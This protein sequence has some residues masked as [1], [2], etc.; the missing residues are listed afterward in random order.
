MRDGYLRKIDYLRVSITDRCNLRCFYCLPAGGIPTSPQG[1]IL[2]FEELLELLGVATGNGI[3]RVRITGGEPLVRKG[4]IAFLSRVKA[5]PGV[6][7]LSLTTNGLLLEGS[8]G[9]LRR[10]GVDRLNVS[11][12]SLRQERYREITRGGELNKVLRGI[13]RA[14]REGF[15]SLKLNVLLMRRTRDEIPAFLRLT[16]ERPL[17]VRFI[18]LMPIGEGVA[19][20]GEYLPLSEFWRALEPFHPASVRVEGGGP[21]ECYR[22]PGAAGTVGFIAA[23]S[24]NFCGACRRL[25]LGADGFLYA[26]LAGGGGI[27]LRDPLRR[28]VSRDKL[29]ELFRRAILSKPREGDFRWEKAGGRSMS[30]IGG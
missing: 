14:Q 22:I 13:D 7:D 4:V 8:A 3:R 18:E 27:D 23:V 11:L 15:S 26:C 2:S 29:G 10:A 12:D 5:I 24:H 25:R 20:C 21:A 17:H 6:V 19:Q 16:L 9:G 30:R 1:E 28:G